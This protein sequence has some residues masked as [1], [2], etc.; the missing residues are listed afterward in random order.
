MAASVSVFEW[1]RIEV[2]FCMWWLIVLFIIWLIPFFLLSFSWCSLAKDTH[3]ISVC[4]FIHNGGGPDT[5]SISTAKSVFVVFQPFYGN[6]WLFCTLHRSFSISSFPSSSVGWLYFKIKSKYGFSYRKFPI[7]SGLSTFLL[8]WKTN[9]I[10]WIVDEMKKET[11][12][13]RKKLIWSFIR[14]GIHF[15]F[16]TNILKSVWNLSKIKYKHSILW[17]EFQSVCV[18][19]CKIYWHIWNGWNFALACKYYV[20]FFP[21]IV[22]EIHKPMKLCG[23]KNHIQ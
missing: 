3:F 1:T 14:H 8:F 20:I 5:N 18:C 7:A 19:I 15:E 2:C 10:V 13:N 11:E 22:F 12:R 17:Y 16:S 6:N 9:W 4:V 21:E 23:H